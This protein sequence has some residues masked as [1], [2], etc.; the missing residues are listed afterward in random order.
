MD[1][2]GH[3]FTA[4]VGGISI[5][6]GALSKD[7]DNRASG[8]ASGASIDRPLSGDLHALLPKCPRTCIE[9]DFRIVVIE[10]EKS[11]MA[12]IKLSFW[13][14]EGVNEMT[15][16]TVIRNWVS[17]WLKYVHWYWKIATRPDANLQ[18]YLEG[19][20]VERTWKIKTNDPS[21]EIIR[22][23]LVW[24]L[25]N[26]CSGKGIEWMVPV[27]PE[28]LSI[29]RP[30]SL[31]EHC[32]FADCRFPLL[33]SLLTAA[34]ESNPYSSTDVAE[35]ATLPDQSQTAAVSL[36]LIPLGWTASSLPATYRLDYFHRTAVSMQLTESR[37]K[38]SRQVTH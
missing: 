34:L 20:V 11:C 33:L 29:L 15:E 26:M 5:H 6:F 2:V 9:K 4:W 38:S 13:A 31:R 8:Q 16:K 37:S 19:P 14:S 27:L 35:P 24:K 17:Q 7:K 32:C 18:E 1:Q 12:E 30:R 3:P 21:T 28:K 36:L 10:R 25:L 23:G 22:F